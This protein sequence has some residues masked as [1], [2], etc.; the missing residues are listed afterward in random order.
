MAECVCVCVCMCGCVCVSVSSSK[1]KIRQ[2]QRPADNLQADLIHE[3]KQILSPP[4]SLPEVKYSLAY[5]MHVC[6]SARE[7][8]VCVW[9]LSARVRLSVAE[10][11]NGD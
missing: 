10:C 3:M 7:S 11:K 2:F 8:G 4:Y 5:V 1:S 9:A 6:V